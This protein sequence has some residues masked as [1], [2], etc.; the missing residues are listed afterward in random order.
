MFSLLSSWFRCVK[1]LKHIEDGISNPNPDPLWESGKDSLVIDTSL[2]SG[3]ICGGGIKKINGIT[4][5]G[6]LGSIIG[7]GS[8]CLYGEGG[9]CG[10][11][12]SLATSKATVKNV[13]NATSHHL[14]TT[15]ISTITA[16]GTAK[17]PTSPPPPTARPS[18]GRLQL[19]I[20]KTSSSITTS[21]NRN[22]RLVEGAGAAGAGEGSNLLSWS[23]RACTFLNPDFLKA[24]LQCT[25]PK[26][27]C[28]GDGRSS[29][30]SASSLII[31]SASKEDKT[32]NK[33]KLWNDMKILKISDEAKQL[34]S[35]FESSSSD[36]NATSII[37]PV[38]S[39]SSS[40]VS[41]AAVYP[42]GASKVINQPGGGQLV[43]KCNVNEHDTMPKWS[44]IMCTYD[45]WP[46]SVKC[47][48][49]G[50][51][52][53][54]QPENEQANGSNNLVASGNNRANHVKA[55]MVK[56]KQQR[57]PYER[58]SLYHRE[59]VDAL[60]LEACRGVVEGKIEAVEEYLAAGGDP[61][62]QLTETEV[63]IL[64]RPS[65]FDPG[66]TLVHLALR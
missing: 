22:D 51:S 64:A 63:E 2:G 16:V 48:M 4:S 40:V 8:D 39:R 30:L 38:V 59:D 7:R 13:L 9:A 10:G 18:S 27:T 41:A 26:P 35:S 58:E 14:K 62:R 65:A 34:G 37:P 5:T 42:E 57:S 50:T 25:T 1:P 43:K 56:S 19:D 44:C 23:C 32:S 36:N 53:P 21:E 49:C 61:T 31:S 52:A 47:I 6:G 54:E 45:N 20:I 33:A 3:G 24:C 55:Q 66:F 29:P 46:R 12:A 15:N 60:F 11:A 17:S 28:G